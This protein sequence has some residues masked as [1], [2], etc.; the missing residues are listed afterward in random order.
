M[1]GHVRSC[2]V[3]MAVMMAVIPPRTLGA[4][5]DRAAG[6]KGSHGWSWTVKDGQE[7]SK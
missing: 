6:G 4:V 3:M 5:A 2:A 7:R 1:E